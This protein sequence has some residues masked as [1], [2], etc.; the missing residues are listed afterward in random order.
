MVAPA[1]GLEEV[2]GGSAKADGGTGSPQDNME[3]SS[4]KSSLWSEDTHTRVRSP[5]GKGEESKTLAFDKGYH[6][7]RPERNS[8]ATSVSVNQ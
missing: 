2:W 7:N 1:G 6:G 4:L 5:L 8:Y 3:S